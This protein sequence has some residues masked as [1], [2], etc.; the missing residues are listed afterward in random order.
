MT[1]TVGSTAPERGRP[2]DEKKSDLSRRDRKRVSRQQK[3]GPFARLSI[4]YRQIIAE[5][6]KV[7]WPN[8]PELANYTAVVIAFVVVIMGVVYGLDWAF[9]KLS[10]AIFG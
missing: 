8:R 4:F 9:S 2:E 5:L 1:E 3:K 7:V 6:R 10:F